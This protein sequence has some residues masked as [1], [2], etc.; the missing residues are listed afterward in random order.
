MKINIYTNTKSGGKFTD[1]FPYSTVTGVQ[2][3]G[4]Q[5]PGDEII[6]TLDERKMTPDKILATRF[7]EFLGNRRM[8]IED[9]KNLST[10][11]QAEIRREFIEG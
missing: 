4:P 5:S 2:S 8:T 10:E 11:G 7:L 9:L 6:K 1:A 3:E